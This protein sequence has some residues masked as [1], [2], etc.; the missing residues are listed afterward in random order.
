M[1]LLMEGMEKRGWQ[2]H[3]ALFRGGK[4]FE[5]LA[6]HFPVLA[7]ASKS[8]Y[9]PGSIRQVSR[10]CRLNGI[11]IMD[12]HSSK[13]H[14][15]AL[16]VKLLNPDLKLVVHR[17]VDYVPGSDFFSRW[18]YGSKRVNRFVAI[19]DYIA[20]V[21]MDYGLPVDRID[22]VRSAIDGSS[23]KKI[24]AAL[25]RKKWRE[26]L[27]LDKE[28]QL[29]VC[30]AAL[31]QQKAIDVLLKAL[32]NR[33]G[34]Q[35]ALCV[36]AGVGPL[37]DQLKE[38]ARRLGLGPDRVRFLGWVEGVAGLLAA[39]DVFVLPSRD[40]GL[41]TI[42]LEAAHAGL[43]I[44]ACSVGGIPEIVKDGQTGLLVP[45]EDPPAMAG[46]LDRLLQDPEWAK[47]LAANAREHVESSFSIDQM[48]QGNL[49][50]YGSL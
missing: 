50:V 29:V 16:G 31:S 33:A 49:Q 27:E 42:L 47:M 43:P 45:K 37:E 4:A 5:K 28:Q 40:E 21:L 36:I 3:A 44:L 24:D 39:G 25:N 8:S 6:D 35:S 32:A 14:A 9:S 1:R 18:K 20:K 41:G 23:Y 2:P 26:R 17:R 48:V 15:L 12:A 34:Q 46:A 19:S 22:T 38:Q 11:E 10:Y 7:L 13:G 30:A